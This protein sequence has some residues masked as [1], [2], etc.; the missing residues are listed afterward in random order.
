VVWYGVLRDGLGGVKFD[1]RSRESLTWHR[2][3]LVGHFVFGYTL[4]VFICVI[5]FMGWRVNQNFQ[6]LIYKG[7]G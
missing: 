4:F 2:V 6:R 5:S 1:N 7:K 3:D